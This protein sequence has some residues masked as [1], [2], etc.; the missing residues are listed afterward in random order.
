MAVRR[1]RHPSKNGQVSDVQ[2]LTPQVTDLAR[3]SET[4]KA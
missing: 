3:C 4:K 1:Q 2:R